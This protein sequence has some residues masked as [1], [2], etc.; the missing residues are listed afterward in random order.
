MHCKIDFN[1]TNF[2][3]QSKILAVL[4][5]LSHCPSIL[6]CWPKCSMQSFRLFFVPKSSLNINFIIA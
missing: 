6:D 3:Q 1:Y 2:V 4:K 5:E